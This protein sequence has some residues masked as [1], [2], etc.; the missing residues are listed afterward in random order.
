MMKFDIVS[1]GDHLID[2][3]THKHA[4]T[5]AQRFQMWVDL[6]VLADKLGF[7]AA[8]LGE[9]HCSDYVISA[10]H[11]LLAAAAVQT[12]TIRLGTAVSLLPNNDPVRMAEDFATLDLLSNGRA[13][14][15]FGSGFTEHTFRLFGQDTTNSVEMSRENLELLQLLWTKDA[16]D[17]QGKFR[18][19]IHESR[20]EPRT[21]TGRALPIH[22]ATATSP[23]TAREAGKAGFQ[24]MILAHASGFA[25]SA[26]LAA[27]YREAYRAAGHDPAGMSVAVP[28]YVHVRH[29]GD[30]ARRFFQPYL[31]NYRSFTKALTTNKVATRGIREAYAKMTPEMMAKREADFVGTPREVADQILRA[32]SIFSGLDRLMCYFDCGCVPRD[33]V[34]ATVDLF[35]KEVIP[36]VRASALLSHE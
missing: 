16:I 12:K 8:W 18:A 31:A 26:G 33:D 10:P 28:V 23:D 29:D 14:V 34:F 7:H 32:S 1:L 17:W 13:D 3:H 4:E 30:E 5:Q 24:L 22:R 20:I 21:F 19:P 11:M 15:G 6:I 27:T 36:L 25:A 35:A 2:P 9:H